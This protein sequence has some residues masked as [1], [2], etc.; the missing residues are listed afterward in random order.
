MGQVCAKYE[1]LS[2]IV[3]EGPSTA[4]GRKQP[5]PLR[6]MWHCQTDHPSIS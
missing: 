4:A 3:K 6:V 5:C 2:T 1:G